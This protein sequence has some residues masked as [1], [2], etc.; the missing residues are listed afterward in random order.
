MYL[1]SE[2]ATYLSTLAL[3][4]PNTDALTDTP[5]LID[6]DTGTEWPTLILTNSFANR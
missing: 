5:A 3:T 4:K 1:L 6:S 2:S